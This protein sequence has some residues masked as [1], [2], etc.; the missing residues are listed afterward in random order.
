MLKSISLCFHTHTEEKKTN[1]KIPKCQGT[2][3]VLSFTQYLKTSVKLHVFNMRLGPYKS[4]CGDHSRRMKLPS[5]SIYLTVWFIIRQP[6]H[7]PHPTECQASGSDIK[8]VFQLSQHDIL[9]HSPSFLGQRY[10]KIFQCK[11]L[12]YLFS[13]SQ[14]S[15]AADTSRS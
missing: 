9:G 14:Q 3:P 7:T 1:S 5:K 13:T 15:S 6:D 4:Q 2:T 11:F 8:S 12:S 10:Q